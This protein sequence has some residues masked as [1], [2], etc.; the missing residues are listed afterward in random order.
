V[1]I[2][3]REP[4]RYQFEAHPHAAMVQL[5]DLPRIIKYKK[6]KL[7]ERRL[8]LD[9]YRELMLTRLPLLSPPMAKFTLPDL[10]HT[11]AAMKDIED[12]M[13]AV[14][15]AYVAAHWW[16]WGTARNFL[17]GTRE[18]GYIVVPHR[19]AAKSHSAS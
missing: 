19:H 12:R 13:D 8:E 15:C 16:Y 17:Q 3:A 11:G 5:F 10:P 2:A 4:G 7:S 14:I 18:E 1:A 9:R 6:G